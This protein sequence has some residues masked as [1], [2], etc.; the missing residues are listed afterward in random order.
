MDFSRCRFFFSF[1]F[2]ADAVKSIPDQF[3]D[4]SPLPDKAEVLFLYSLPLCVG[5]RYRVL[6]V[7]VASVAVCYTPESSQ[8]DLSRLSTS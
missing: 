1:V 3:T 2:H 5:R 6:S 8:V 7:E 4:V